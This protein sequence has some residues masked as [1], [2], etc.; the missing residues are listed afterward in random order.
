MISTPNDPTV[1]DLFHVI[2]DRIQSSDLRTN[3]KLVI[4]TMDCF[5]KHFRTFHTKVHF[6]LQKADLNIT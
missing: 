5:A 2:C 3:K 4:I 6:T 1:G